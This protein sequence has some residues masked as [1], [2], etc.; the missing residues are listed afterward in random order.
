MRKKKLLTSA[1]IFGMMT[2]GLLLGIRN[3]AD[4]ADTDVIPSIM[5]NEKVVYLDSKDKIA[6]QGENIVSV[7][8]SSSKKKIA[9]ISN[10]GKLVPKKKGKTTIKAKVVY[11][12]EGGR[13]QEK[14]LSYKVQ[15]K[16]KVK[17]YF[18]YKKSSDDT[19]KITG[20]TKKGSKLS[21]IYIPE[22]I[23]KYAVIDIKEEAFQNNKTIK[24]LYLSDNIEDAKISD[25]SNLEKLSIGK[26][27]EGEYYYES[28]ISG[29]SSL[30]EIDLDERN[31]NYMLVDGV[32]FSYN[33][34]VLCYYPQKRADTV[35]IVPEGVG[36][37]SARAFENSK[38]L[39][40]IALPDTIDTFGEYCFA[41]S[42]INSITISGYI[43]TLAEGMFADCASL[44]EVT[45]PANI[46]EIPE[47]LFYNC[48]SLKHFTVPQRTKTVESSAF[49]N[50]SQFTTFNVV[51]SNTSF[52]AVDGILYNKTETELVL[53]PSGRKEI[54]YTVKDGIKKI[55]KGAFYAVPSLQKVVIPSTVTELK[56]KA[57][58]K[59]GLKEIEIPNSVKSIK[60]R[61][62]SECANLADVVLPEN[63]A[64]LDEYVFENCTALTQITLPKELLTINTDCFSGCDKLETI[65]VDKGNTTYVSVNGILFSKSQQTLYYYPN[66]KKESSYTVPKTVR[67]IKG[68]A[69]SQTKNLEKIIVPD[70]VNSIEEYAFSQ[71]RSMKWIKLPK[72]LSEKT[73]L[74]FSGCSSLKKVTLPK[75][76]SLIHI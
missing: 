32:L 67:N 50:C 37:I 54:S 46:T 7:K 35:Y 19:Y 22:S 71:C 16:G 69:F 68:F 47:K 51:E 39:K 74:S 75:G 13:K 48:D 21:K 41:G 43:N 33:K 61:V 5:G 53:Y 30:K 45:L 8:Y 44:S 36:D 62:F 12:E 15:V 76:L 56:E 10:K 64:N 18:K 42:G 63:L 72:K 38:N 34:D 17:E 28:F 52:T 25:C 58:S 27:F 40:S 24:E 11:R 73:K 70:E 6:I 60:S 20:L 14:T 9:T 29:C 23:G 57:F 2:C 55:G 26:D 66:G 59:S 3:E 4:A 1:M 65:A 31:E 49:E